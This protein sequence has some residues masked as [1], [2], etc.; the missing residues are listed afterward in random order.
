MPAILMESPDHAFMHVYTTTEK[1]YN[2]GIGWRVVVT[3]PVLPPKEAKEEQKSVV[4]EDK[5]YKFPL[6]DDKPK[7]PKKWSM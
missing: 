7:K 4:M 5:E 6:T 2:E 3:P 1:R